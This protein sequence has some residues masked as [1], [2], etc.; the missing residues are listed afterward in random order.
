MTGFSS[1]PA[2]YQ[3]SRKSGTIAALRAR[4]GYA[5]QNNWLLYGTAGLATADL[6]RSFTTTNGANSFTTVNEGDRA[7]GYQ[8]G[9]GAEKRLDSNWS[10]GVEYLYTSLN[11]DDYMVEVGPGT[12]PATNPFLLVNASGTDMRRSEDKFGIHSVRVPASYRF[13]M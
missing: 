5:T 11:D 9:L 4:A 2:A 13:G 10:V 3:F 7:S 1:T 6:D 12:A 8:I